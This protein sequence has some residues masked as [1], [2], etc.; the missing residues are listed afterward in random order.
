MALKIRAETRRRLWWIGRVQAQVFRFGPQP[1]LNG[2]PS[3]LRAEAFC[4]EI[5]RWRWFA[6][7]FIE[8]YRREV[9]AQARAS[10]FFIEG[11]AQA[12]VRPRAPE[13]LSTA[14]LLSGACSCIPEDRWILVA[15]S[16]AAPLIGAG[17]KRNE[18]SE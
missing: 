10:G 8:F 1:C 4:R 6:I 14:Y 13:G 2:F 17:F 9:E 12:L 16:N 15:A 7:A 3:G 11:R 18:T 5:D